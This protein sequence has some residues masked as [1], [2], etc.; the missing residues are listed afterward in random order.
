MAYRATPYST[1]VFSPNMMVYGKG[2]SMPCDIIYG[3]TGA[4]Y[5]RQHCC[6]CEYIDKL[7]TNMVSAYV[8]ARQTMGI[9]ANRQ[10]GIS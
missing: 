6:F 8:H 5:N 4:V 7:R 10:K 3:Q 1:T 9:A 2:N